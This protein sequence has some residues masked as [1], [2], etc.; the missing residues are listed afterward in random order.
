MESVR[1]DSDTGHMHC[2]ARQNQQDPSSDT[3]SGHRIDPSDLSPAQRGDHSEAML[4][5]QDPNIFGRG[6][7]ICSHRQN[8]EP[9]APWT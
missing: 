6:R 4:V 8:A 7:E 1:K 2:L 5:S 3:L 9:H